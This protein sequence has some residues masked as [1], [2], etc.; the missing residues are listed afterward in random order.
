MYNIS[1]LPTPQ[2]AIRITTT[3]HMITVAINL[4]KNMMYT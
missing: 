2:N 1:V 3:I 4:N